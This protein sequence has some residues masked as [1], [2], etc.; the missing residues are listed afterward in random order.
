LEL[1]ERSGLPTLEAAAAG[2]L[3]YNEGRVGNVSEAVALMDRAKP[4]VDSFSREIAAEDPGSVFWLS[5]AEMQHERY[6]DSV[7]HATRVRDL[8]RQ[9]DQGRWLPQIAAVRAWSL[10]SLGRVEESTEALD[11]GIEMAQLTGNRQ[12]EALVQL[13]RALMLT[14][15]GRFREALAAGQRAVELAGPV[16][17]GDHISMYA[18][19]QWAVPVLESG[20]PAKAK[21]LILEVADQNGSLRS[22][23]LWQPLGFSVLTEAEL[24]LGDTGSAERHARRAVELADGL[25]LGQRRSWAHQ[26][27]ARV[28]LANGDARLAI[29]EAREAVVAAASSKARV[30]EGRSLIMLGRAL[31]AA[32]DKETA[33]GE[34][35]RAHDLLDGCGA[36]HYR[37]Q[38]GRELRALGVRLGRSGRRGDADTGPGALS[39]REREI[40]ELVAEGRS[41]KE[42]G[43][44]LFIS[45]KTVEKHLSRAFEKLGVS[46]RAQVAA[47]IERERAGGGG[48]K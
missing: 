11:E 47:A 21:E 19:Q 27:F 35:R 10:W 22:E 24:A 3:A 43:A 45:P 39:G 23:L 20:D 18:R 13:G 6:E 37:D 33:A 5:V 14:P 48:K 44:A 40:A 42:I 17:S 26:A 12:F 25:G 9:T 1:A 2:A 4:L 41:N 16:A 36:F 8:A 28:A 46:K 31:V 32:G 29:G 34:L 7:R 38:A 30:D 15:A